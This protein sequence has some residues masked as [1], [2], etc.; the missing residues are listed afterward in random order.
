MDEAGDRIAQMARL[1]RARH[2]LIEIRDDCADIILRGG[3]RKETAQH[4][5]VECT[6][7]LT[8]LEATFWAHDAI[9]KA[10]GHLSG[11][12]L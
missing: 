1:A 11:V 7:H 2:T 5:W 3:P 8:E 10:Q 12:S 9:L 4:M 6:V